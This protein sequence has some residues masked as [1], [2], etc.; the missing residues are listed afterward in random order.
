MGDAGRI[1]RDIGDLALE[2]GMISADRL[3]E[4]RVEIA[5]RRKAGQIVALGQVLVETGALTA[6]QVEIL[7]QDAGTL[8]APLPD[9][10][11]LGDGGTMRLEAMTLRE[12]QESFG[13]YVDV[14]ELARGGMGAIYKALDPDIGREIA[15]KVLLP[16][17]ADRTEVARFVR[18]GQIT[19]QLEHPNIVPVY[20][21]SQ[22]S[23]SQVHITMKLVKGRSLADVLEDLAGGGKG[24]GKGKGKDPIA[25]RIDLLNAFVKVCDAVAYAH[26]RG[27]IHRDLKPSNIMIGEFG[28][29]LV[30]DWGIAKVLSEKE[31]EEEGQR[32]NFSESTIRGRFARSTD[33]ARTLSGSV[34]GTPAYMPPEQAEGQVE[35]LD[36][37]SDIYSL[38]AVLYEI[39]TLTPPYEA[40]TL[41]EMAVAWTIGGEL[42]PPSSRA[43][44]LHIPEE[45]DAV[46]MKAMA[47]R[48]AN[49]YRHVS[50][51]QSD[52]QAHL[53]GGLLQ[54]VR[55]GPVQRA[56]KWLRRHPA[57]G[58]SIGVAAAGLV[59]LAAVVSLGIRARK[60]ELAVREREF[61]VEKAKET[62]R[63]TRAE[64]LREFEALIASIDTPI[65]QGHRQNLDDGVR[66]TLEEALKKFPEFP[67][68]HRLAGRFH[69]RRFEHG[70]ARS[71]LEEAIRLADAA[72]AADV[73]GAAR[74]ELGLVLLETAG[75]ETL[76]EELRRLA[77]G[78]DPAAAPGPY[79]CLSSLVPL[80]ESN[81]GER[82]EMRRKFAE[83]VR[84]C[85]Q[86]LRAAPDFADL[87]Y[88]KASF[89]SGEIQ[90]R[91]HAAE[92]RDLVHRL[93]MPFGPKQ[94]DERDYAGA[95]ESLRTALSHEP[96]N[97][98]A[99]RSLAIGLL[100]QGRI[101]EG[102]RQLEQLSAALDDSPVVLLDLALACLACSRNDEAVRA[103]ERGQRQFPSE[104][105]LSALLASG[106]LHA[107]RFEEALAAADEGLATYRASPARDSAVG[108]RGPVATTILFA[109]RITALLRLERL[110]QADA[111]WAEFMK[112]LEDSS[113]DGAGF[114]KILRRIFEL[115]E[116]IRFVLNRTRSLTEVPLLRLPADDLVQLEGL[117]D[118][119]SGSVFRGSYSVED[120][121]QGVFD[122]IGDQKF[123]TVSIFLALHDLFGGVDAP[124]LRSHVFGKPTS[125][126]PG[127]LSDL[128]YLMVAPYI[129]RLYITGRVE[130]DE[131]IAPERLA[132][133]LYVIGTPLIALD[134]VERSLRRWSGVGTLH[135]AAAFLRAATDARPDEVAEELAT[136]KALGYDLAPHRSHPVFG[137][138]R[139][140]PAVSALLG[141]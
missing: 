121:Q 36:E 92:D 125:I 47:R 113:V 39:L 27:I 96:G 120:F 63:A 132:G 123:E 77:K 130:F 14:V 100:M 55:Y 79:W 95:E 89:A 31:K 4:V 9:L 41:S 109:A 26:S 105:L 80:L 54:A 141:D 10:P 18:E 111:G 104:W 106:L 87:H 58:A 78:I 74:Y 49:R 34:L 42:E 99:I 126:Q 116:M 137:P 59:V 83:A 118:Q 30:M 44:S 37:R 2:M 70:P 52:V 48:R 72:G 71:R 35:R 90:V 8:L 69:R 82:D 110:E 20:G 114:S 112:Y 98:K 56:V 11:D 73:A 133:A 1:E 84:L 138:F 12:R 21:L 61:E 66:R 19:G 45:L 15:I 62:E 32:S 93:S 124:I 17:V 5:R 131:P 86:G 38:G 16:G 81:E 22:S 128:F 65:L 7:S 53:V 136:A 103:L 101:D 13:R 127:L 57:T 6:S 67:L 139:A 50:E 122:P 97:E 76:L 102:M 140:D 94:G 108:I 43:P 119:F 33:G 29:V 23:D 60:A 91:L 129:G 68:G 24:K 107:N 25:A 46:V 88:W 117:I 135:F 3:L 28:E 51:I 75:A 134:V 64:R 115:P 40:R 85:E